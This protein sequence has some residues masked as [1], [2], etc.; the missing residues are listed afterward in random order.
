MDN[1]RPSCSRDFSEDIENNSNEEISLVDNPGN[2]SNEETVENPVEHLH[3]DNNDTSYQEIGLHGDNNDPSYQEEEIG[4]LREVVSHRFV[5]REFNEFTPEQLTN[6][7]EEADL[8]AKISTCHRLI[9]SSS[10]YENFDKYDTLENVVRD[11]AVNPR[12]SHKMKFLSM[13]R[14]K[15]N[16]RTFR[17]LQSHFDLDLNGSFFRNKMNLLHIA[18]DSGWTSIVQELLSR[19]EIDVNFPT[20][21]LR[22]S[23]LTPLMFAA[24]R[25]NLDVLKLLLDHPGIRLEQSDSYGMTAIFHACNHGVHRVGD[26]LGYFRRLWTS[27]DLSPQHLE[28]M[29]VQARS[30][31]V[32]VIRLLIQAGCDLDARDNTGAS[33]LNRAASVDNFSAVVKELVSVGCKP[34]EN[35]M[36]WTRVRNRDLVPMLEEE[37][38]RPPPLRRQARRAVWKRLRW[39]SASQGSQMSFPERISNMEGDILPSIL[40]EYLQCKHQ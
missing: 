5:M 40:V 2:N 3:G 30:N 27:F 10:I 34:T 37:M 19:D 20:P 28:A 1:D 23:S 13:L 18:S 32:A 35:I 6:I 8:F 12:A 38:T 25:G 11:I 29:E 9:E 17:I 31:A 24:M 33:V 4:V 22:P 15:D 21:S 39:C 26:G 16:A 36:N 14:N 7:R